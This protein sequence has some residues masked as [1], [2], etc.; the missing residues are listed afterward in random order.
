MLSRKEVIEA[1]QILIAVAWKGVLAIGAT[2]VVLYCASEGFLP[3]G[4][5][6]GDAF[7]LVYVSFGFGVL[8]LVGILYGAIAMLW[9]AG[10]FNFIS[11]RIA[12][13]KGKPRTQLHRWISDRF[14]IFGASPLV[15]IAFS[16]GLFFI[17]GAKD[18]RPRET[19]GFF[20]ICGFLTIAIFGVSQRESDVSETASAPTPEQAAN[21]YKPKMRLAIYAAL[22]LVLMISVKPAMLNFTMA[23]L[24]VRSLPKDLVVV[25][26]TTHDRL[27]QL[28]NHSKIS[29]RFCPLEG[30]GEWA[31][32][33][34]R[35]VWGGVGSKS[36]LRLMDIN[37]GGDR[38]I[39][40]PVARDSVDV[41]RTERV[42][43][44]CE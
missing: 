14:L 37:S 8:A 23:N 39:L 20:L 21:R 12:S 28:A 17:D 13:K 43:F 5:S 19:I 40:V 29:I 18:M 30:S 11:N 2:L 38:S 32:R 1:V 42:G 35:S 31:S 9:V 44:V 33:D 16:V 36:Y 25:N 26:Q 7:L 10:T 4:F 3:D 6:L 27:I 41:V 24:G 34:I 22:I 15:F